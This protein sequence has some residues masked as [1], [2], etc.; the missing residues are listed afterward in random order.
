[1]AG[2]PSPPTVDMCRVPAPS[3]SGPGPEAEWWAGGGRGFRWLFRAHG[4]QRELPGCAGRLL[5][6]AWALATPECSKA[7][8]GA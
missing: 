3:G 7:V 1:M 5:T 8:S 2:S 6:P 4:L